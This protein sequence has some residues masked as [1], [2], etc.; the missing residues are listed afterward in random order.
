MLGK[1]LIFRQS[2]GGVKS[3]QIRG[4]L[5]NDFPVEQLCQRIPDP[6]RQP[7]A[8]HLE[9]QEDQGQTPLV[10]GAEHVQSEVDQGQVVDLHV[11]LS[12]L[13]EGAGL[14]Q[15]ES[16][17]DLE[18]QPS[19]RL[20]LRLLEEGVAVAHGVG[21][22]VELGQT[23][24]GTGN[25]VEQLREGVE[26]VEDLGDEEEEEGLGEVPEDGHHGEGHPTEVA[27]G[28]T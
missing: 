15:P 25:E 19:Q 17:Q 14:N 4:W 8:Q 23:M 13:V 22:R 7:A 10:H 24:A 16:G 21:V 3:N 9:R 20:H 27:E 12:V 28:V 6:E 26:K 5:R 18:C 11:A 1:S 2:R